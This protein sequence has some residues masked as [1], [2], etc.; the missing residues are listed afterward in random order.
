MLRQVQ[1]SQPSVEWIEWDEA[2]LI[3]LFARLDAWPEYTL[4]EGELSI[5]FLGHDDMA[6]VHGQFL[7]DATPT[8]VITFPGDPE[9]DFA[10]EIC[11]GVQ[12]AIEVGPEHGHDLAREVTLYLVHGWLHLAGLDDRKEADRVQMRLAEKQALAYLD[13]TGGL[14]DVRLA[15][16]Q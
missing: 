9:M 16:S 2:Q 8:D 13:N 1:L 6:A 10:G 7:D 14:A 12:Q 5:A 15:G 3:G 11:V 4:P